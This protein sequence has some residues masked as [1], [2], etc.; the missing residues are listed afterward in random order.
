MPASPRNGTPALAEILVA[1]LSFVLRGSLAGTAGGGLAGALLAVIAAALEPWTVAAGPW[2]ATTGFAAI[3][4][5][6]LGA[7][8]GARGGFLT[9]IVLLLL[10]KYSLAVSYTHL[11]LPTKA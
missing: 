11:T 9:A 10:K 3:L 2:L 5:M 1:R 6:A 7:W 4:A 8:S